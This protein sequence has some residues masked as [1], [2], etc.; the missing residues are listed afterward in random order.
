MVAVTIGLLIT[1]GVLGLFVSNRAVYLETE[2]IT[3]LQENSRFALEYLTDDLR[4]AGFFG[5]ARLSVIENG[6][7]EANLAEDEK[8]CSRNAAVFEFKSP[9]HGA[10]ATS[11]TVLGCIDDAFVIDGLPS[12]VLVI[13]SVKPRP[14][15]DDDNSGTVGDTGDNDGNGRIDAGDRLEVGRAYIV[16]NGLQGQLL[17]ITATAQLAEVPTVSNPGDYPHGAFWE[18]DFSAYYVRKSDGPMDPPTLARMRLDWD[19]S[20]LI[21]DTEDLAEGVEGLRVLYGLDTDEDR[22]ADTYL[23]AERISDD[24]WQHV[25]HVA[26]YL[27]V[28]TTR[29]MH[30]YSD[31]KQYLLGDTVV[32]ATQ[33]ATTTQG[34][35]LKN[36]RRAVVST[37]VNLRNMHFTE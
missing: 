37:T 32:T 11:E 21:L 24:D 19:G 36:F 2:D 25:R 20:D 10:V 5:Q 26:V 33:G 6:E 8:D 14:Y 4:H 22:I 27:L 18:Y 16:S 34:A 17:A 12:D 3:E 28:R 1:A 35:A 23:G 9:V 13:K 30:S 29:P 31:T 7:P 15:R